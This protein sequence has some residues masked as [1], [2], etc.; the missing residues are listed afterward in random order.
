MNNN[1][2]P[3][4]SSGTLTTRQGEIKDSH[5]ASLSASA[6]AGAT[7]GSSVAAAAAGP[8][9][10]T[11]LVYGRFSARPTVPRFRTEDC[12]LVV[13]DVPVQAQA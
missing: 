9:P 7:P 1:K 2:I 13:F 11:G 3:A 8:G 5:I 6:S 10:P 4:N 12:C